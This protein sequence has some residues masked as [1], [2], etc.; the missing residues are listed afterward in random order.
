MTIIIIVV[1]ILIIVIEADMTLAQFGVQ[2]YKLSHVI[3]DSKLTQCH[4]KIIKTIFIIVVVILII[5]IKLSS[6]SKTSQELRVPP[7]SLSH[8]QS[9]TRNVTITVS[10]L[11]NTQMW[12]LVTVV[13]KLYSV[14][15]CHVVGPL[16]STQPHNVSNFLFPPLKLYNKRS[17]E[18]IWHKA[19]SNTKIHFIVAMVTALSTHDGPQALPCSGTRSLMWGSVVPRRGA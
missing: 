10:H 4:Q 13:V 1:V 6:L 3:L 8:C 2:Y 14:C 16:D 5:I 18:K 19:G 7:R 11:R 15:C 17:K 12:H 9:L